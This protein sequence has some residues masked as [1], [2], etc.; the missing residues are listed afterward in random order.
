[1]LPKPLHLGPEYAAQFGDQGVVEAY[2]HRPPYPDEAFA[3][4]ADLIEDEPRAVLDVGCGTGELARR[5]APL[6]DRVDAVDVSPPMIEVGRR[7][8]GGERPN[9]VWILAAAEEAALRPPY[10]LITAG[11]SLHWMEWDVVLPRFG[12]A[13]TPNGTLVLVGQETSP[14][15]WDDDLQR[16]IDRYSTNRHYQPYDLV[17]E[18]SARGLF[19]RVGERRT[20]PV[21]F[22]QTVDEYVASFHARNGFSRE[23]MGPERAA[24]FDAAVSSLVRGHCPSGRV[25]LDVVGVVTW[26]QPGIA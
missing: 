2:R 22:A 15:P 8:P 13:L 7:S 11:A 25:G 9:L 12:R 16:L 19:R 20:A 6:V 23:R 1:M 21:E 4:L 17:A 24:A 10:A 18:L 3:I 26:G 5:L 14:A